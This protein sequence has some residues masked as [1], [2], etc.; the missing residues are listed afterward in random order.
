VDAHHQ[1]QPEVIA[2][3]IAAF[4]ALTACSSSNTK[5]A[6]DPAK[7]TAAHEVLPFVHDDYPRALAEARKRK[8][9]IFV[10]SWAPWC[11]SCLSMKSYVFTDPALA[12]LADRFVW[13]AIDTERD[14]NAA[15]VAKF[16]HEALPTLWLVDPETEQVIWRWTGTLT[17]AELR[18][19]LTKDAKESDTP[20][21]AAHDRVMQLAK[22]DE[23]ACAKLA[24]AEA[25]TLARGTPR[26]DVIATGLECAVSSKLAVETEELASLA[27]KDATA[28]DA[29]LLADD[30]SA[31]FEAVVETKK[32]L[33][34]APAVK[35]TA[36]RWAAF[37]E[38]EASKAKT[39]AARAVFDAHRLGAYLALGQPERAVPMLEQSERDFPDDYNPPA[40]LARAHLE[41]KNLDAAAAAVERARTR[42]YGPRIMR[43]LAMAADIAKAR[44]DRAAERK[45]LEEALARTE[46]ATLTA[47][48]KKVRDG[49]AKRLSELQ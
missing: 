46:K 39:P 42:V 28:T 33:G 31:L 14:S 24:L 15:F 37:L 48:Q 10:D 43:V 38:G 6:S 16:T 21:R 22:G 8:K 7:V 44:G 41:M 32:A 13:L 34:D 26:A 25:K 30:R 29:P 49:L 20:V 40:R 9:P 35:A 2:L 4:V 1:R 47:G 5:P 11:H 27:L 18:D 19:A 45:A 3:A 17:V 36:E 23:A 12:P